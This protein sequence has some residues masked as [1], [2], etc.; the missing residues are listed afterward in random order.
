MKVIQAHDAEQAVLGAALINPAC[1][2]RL[3]GLRPEHFLDGRNGAIWQAI[4]EQAQ[5]GDVNVLTVQAR[6]NGHGDMSYLVGLLTAVPT[7]LHAEAYADLVLDAARRRGWLADASALA[8]AAYQGDGDAARAA[9]RSARARLQAAARDSVAPAHAVAAALWDDLADPAALAQRVLPLGLSSLDA[10]TGGAERATCVCFFARPSMG[11]SAALVQISDAVTERG[12]RCLVLTKEHTR[13]QWLRR[14]AFRRVRANWQHWRQGQ[15]DPADQQRVLDEVARLGE[16]AGLHFDDTPQTSAQALDAARRLADRLGGLDWIIADHLRKFTDTG[17]SEVKR[18]GQISDA[19]KRIAG[20]LDCVSVI[21]AQLSRGVEG[22]EDKRP[23]LRD[24]RD[25]GEIEE[26][27]DDGW[28]IYRDAY[29]HPGSKAGSVT[30]FWLRKSREGA[31]NSRSEMVFL[32]E[33]MSF[34]PL[35]RNTNGREYPYDH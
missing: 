23:D 8:Q 15:I 13:K 1:L 26:N 11:K 4:Q 14:M 27:I 9:V 17:D 21:A 33:H 31:R 25:S 12:E 10:A 18:L 34:E 20:E 29:Y 7:A 22:R 32:P 3:S 16:R 6:L 5:A 28:A 24:L 2:R 35:E 19:F 30:E